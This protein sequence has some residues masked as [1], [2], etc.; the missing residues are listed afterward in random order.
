MAPCIRLPFFF[1]NSGVRDGCHRG[2]NLHKQ[3]EQQPV[4]FNVEGAR[5]LQPYLRTIVGTE[6]LMPP[7]GSHC[8]HS[9]DPAAICGI[10]G[11]DAKELRKHRDGDVQHEG[12]MIF[13]RY[14]FVASVAC[15]MDESCVRECRHQLIDDA[16]TGA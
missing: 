11:I 8:G 14:S 3:P 9:I 6:T 1:V 2:D 5:R 12:R 10:E 7:G 16:K 4:C 13:H 15:D